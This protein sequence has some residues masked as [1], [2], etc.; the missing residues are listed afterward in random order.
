[1]TDDTNQRE[2]SRLK[3]SVWLLGA[4]LCFFLISAALHL[5]QTGTLRVIDIAVPIWGLLLA[6]YLRR[7]RAAQAKADD[8]A[9]P[10]T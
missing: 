1:M 3:R 4:A 2:I 8:A 7:L 6:G 9:G 5:V 10:D